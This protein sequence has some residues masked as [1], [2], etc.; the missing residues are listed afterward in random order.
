VAPSADDVIAAAVS[1]I[2]YAKTSTSSIYNDWYGMSGYWCAMF[3]SWCAHQAGA[4]DTV[5][6]RHSYT[7]NG[8]AW[9]RARN[10]WANGTA[11]I[12]RGDV[13]YFD[14]G[15]GRISH[16]G[17]VEKSI[18]NGTFY[19]VEGNTSSGDGSQRSGGCVAR[20]Q[21]GAKFVVG[22]GRP[23]YTATTPTT[24]PTP[25]EDDMRHTVIVCDL[26]QGPEYG[27]TAVI[28]P[29]NGWT[30]TS[31]GLGPR[32]ELQARTAIANAL[33]FPVVEKHVDQNGWLM[34]QQRY[35]R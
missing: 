10:A 11:G 20:K 33:G 16:V 13:V 28:D 14:F 25:E 5:I 22:Y 18:S 4:L 27:S 32:D 29:I 15:V 35:T 1:Q 24:P 26:A 2:G 3:V 7:P 23:G 21:R 19:S 8:A 17:I 30:R 12:Q 34:A 31:T 9:F 6:P